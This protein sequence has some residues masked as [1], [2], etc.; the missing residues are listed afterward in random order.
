MLLDEE[1]GA[2]AISRGHESTHQVP[3]DLLVEGCPPVRAP[4]DGEGPVG[5]AGG[6]RLFRG[7]ERRG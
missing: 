3:D 7:P 2:G 6:Q 1:G 5:L 4:E